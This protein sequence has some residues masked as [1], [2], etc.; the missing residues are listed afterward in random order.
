[1][2]Y[3]TEKPQEVIISQCVRERNCEDR[4]SALPDDLLVK[5]L[6]FVPTKDIVTTMILSK[7]WRTIW[8]EV[9]RLE[10][11]D[12][13]S[14]TNSEQKSV[15]WFLEKSLQLHKA[16][17]LESLCIQLKEIC[18]TNVDVAKLVGQAVDRSLRRLLFHLS[19]LAKPTSMPN[20]LYTCE[21]LTELEL[22]NKI[23]LDIPPSV[24]L[25]S[26][27]K[28]YL[29][30]VLYKDDVSLV[31]LLSNC[32]VLRILIVIRSE[33]DG[34]VKKYTVKVP[35][36]EEFTYLY[37]RPLSLA[38]NTRSLVL[39]CPE[40]LALS[41]ICQALLEQNCLLFATL[42]KNS[43]TYFLGHV[44][45]RPDNFSQLVDL[46]ITP[47]DSGWLEQLMLM[48]KSNNEL[49]S[50][51][52][53]SSYIITPVLWN[54]PGHVPKC[55]ASHLE[56]FKWRSYNDIKEEREFV[57]YILANSKC[58]KKAEFVMP[59]SKNIYDENNICEEL[60]SMFKISPSCQIT[61]TFIHI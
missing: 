34:N 36:L 21:T 52:I 45:C 31:R 48:L 35:S 13:V 8:T 38:E 43:E 6:L 30:C 58:L 5:I 10:Y 15:W 44:M 2:I 24:C 33:E 57:A 17:I 39:D 27:A 54:K 3:A 18:P 59:N 7:R 41:G 37:K 16:P 51:T 20:I 19:W 1:M 53:K 40:T 26:L 42:T 49:K 32:P 28:L 23:I 47:C 55:L 61:F 50:L 12:I 11:E 56:F 4:I 14:N 22:F 29:F 60:K 25:P 46:T 9:P